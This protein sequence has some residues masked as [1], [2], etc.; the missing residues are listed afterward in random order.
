[1]VL[2]TFADSDHSQLASVAKQLGNIYTKGPAHPTEQQIFDLLRDDTY[3]PYRRRTL[4]KPFDVYE[5]LI[6][7]DV[8]LV[9]GLGSLSPYCTTLHAFVATPNDDGEIMQIPW[10]VVSGAIRLN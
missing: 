5:G 4:P 7:F 6:L 8:R 9:Y 10:D 2:G 3:H 1:L